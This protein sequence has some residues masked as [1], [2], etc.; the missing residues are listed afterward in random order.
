MTNERSKTL[1]VIAGRGSRQVG[2]DQTSDVTNIPRQRRR[3]TRAETGLIMGSTAASRPARGCQSV[4]PETTEAT[5]ICQRLQITNVYMAAG[6][7][8]SKDVIRGGDVH[9]IHDYS[10]VGARA[11]QCAEQWLHGQIRRSARIDHSFRSR[12]IRANHEH[13]AAACRAEHKNR[14]NYGT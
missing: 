3:K 9:R 4:V 7:C 6:T 2:I 14:L 13:R 10:K 8:I 11:P 12:I 5:R 1:G